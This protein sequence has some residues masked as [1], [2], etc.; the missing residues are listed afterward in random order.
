M[1][2]VIQLYPQQRGL[3]DDAVGGSGG[4]AVGRDICDAAVVAG[5]APPCR[6]GRPDEHFVERVAGD[7]TDFAATPGSQRYPIERV[8]PMPRHVGE[9]GVLVDAEVVGVVDGG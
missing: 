3:A 8:G 5:A 2:G 4:S 7:M 9:S 6:A 1:G